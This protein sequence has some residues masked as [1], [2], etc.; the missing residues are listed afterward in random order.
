MQHMDP[1]I[2][3][4]ATLLGGMRLDQSNLSNMEKNLVLTSTCNDM[5]FDTWAKALV[6]QHWDTHSSHRGGHG[7][8]HADRAAPRAKGWQKGSGWNS[9]PKAYV[10][11]A[12]EGEYDD[13]YYYEEEYSVDD[14][15]LATGRDSSQ[16]C[17]DDYS[18]D[19][20]C[21]SCRAEAFAHG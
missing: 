7:D 19:L 18:Y 17:H 8:G 1:S 16:A 3:M 15:Y 6:D 20:R 4:S 11:A 5:S 2:S 9:H 13:G 12:D 10:A 21:N 14:F